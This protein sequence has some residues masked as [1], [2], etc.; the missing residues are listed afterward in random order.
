MQTLWWYFWGMALWKVKTCPSRM[1]SSNFFLFFS[2]L[3]WKKENNWVAQTLLALNFYIIFHDMKEK[4]SI[5]I[6]FFSTIFDKYKN[7][8]VGHMEIVWADTF[9]GYFTNCFHGGFG[10]WQAFIVFEGKSIWML[11][12]FIYL[13]DLY[14]LISNSRQRTYIIILSPAF[15]TALWDESCCLPTQDDAYL[16][17]DYYYQKLPLC[18]RNDLFIY[19]S[20][21]RDAGQCA[22][23]Y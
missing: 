21:G 20:Q 2:F 12:N 9:V 3:I 13:L 6:Y 11:I 10:H 18:W 4:L 8:K 15:P 22:I 16:F 23:K 7:S 14:Y 5:S 19:F 17:Q 1:A